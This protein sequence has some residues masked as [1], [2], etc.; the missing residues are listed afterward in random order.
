[1]R[2]PPSDGIAVSGDRDAGDGPASSSRVTFES[3]P[4]NPVIELVGASASFGRVLSASVARWGAIMVG[5]GWGGAGGRWE[6]SPTTRIGAY[7]EV[8][9]RELIRLYV[10]PFK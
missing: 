7:K 4:P 6:G 9:S 2:N 5:L 10:L 8:L 1:M 3:P